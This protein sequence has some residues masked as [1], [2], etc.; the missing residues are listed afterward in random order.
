M[1]M[2]LKLAS[3]IEVGGRASRSILF[4]KKMVSV[5][6]KSAAL[7]AI[8]SFEVTTFSF[9]CLSHVSIELIS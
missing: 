2:I 4:A 5:N 1:T 6:F 8:Q 3:F 7:H 9:H